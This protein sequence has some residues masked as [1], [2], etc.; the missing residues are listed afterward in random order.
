[1]EGKVATAKKRR[2]DPGAGAGAWTGAAANV[3][4]STGFDADARG[5]APDRVE[6]AWAALGRVIDP[7]VGL[8]IVSMGL[9]YGVE[10]WPDGS[11][12]VEMT[13]T[14]P[15]CPLGSHI[16]EAAKEALRRAFPDANVA[17]HL[18]WQP[19]WSPAM[20]EPRALKELQ[21]R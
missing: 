4:T 10:V 15:G 18:V 6:A 13:L 3:A 7:E 20:I 2:L 17:V 19:P 16:V 12:Q 8:D 11:V 1:M 14:T 5:V 21:R 9:V